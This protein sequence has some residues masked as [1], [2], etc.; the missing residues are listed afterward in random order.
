[1]IPSA[2][3]EDSNRIKNF[4]FIA[5]SLTAKGFS[6]SALF[7]NS[8]ATSWISKATSEK[9][10]N[11]E[12]ALPNDG[13]MCVKKIGIVP[14]VFGN[15]QVAAMVA[16]PSKVNVTMST[17]AAGKGKGAK[18]GAGKTEVSVDFTSS[19]GSA[20]VQWLTVPETC[21]ISRVV[22]SFEV[23]AADTG[24]AIAELYIDAE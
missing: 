2:P 18:N 14:G 12:V 19:P 23:E 7:D 3:A 16:A 13:G 4:L 9:L 1:V 21:K 10:P 20:L 15:D 6:S 8:L 22:L 5:T 24:V 17:A 11:I